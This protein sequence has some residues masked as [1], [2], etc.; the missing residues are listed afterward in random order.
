MT[1]SDDRVQRRCRLE[2]ATSAIR[3]SS[4]RTL[5]SRYDARRRASTDTRRFLPRTRLR[6]PQL[7]RPPAERRLCSVL[8]VDLV[9]VTP[10]A[11]ERDPEETR[12]LPSFCFERAQAIVADYEGTVEKFICDAVMAV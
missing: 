4:S 1:G 6:Y 3:I 10:V 2:S 9:G 7:Q 11:E 5:P 8:F 12:G